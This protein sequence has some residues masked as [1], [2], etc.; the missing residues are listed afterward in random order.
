MHGSAWCS[1]QNKVFLGFALHEISSRTSL[2]LWKR[3]RLSE[4]KGKKERVTPEFGALQLCLIV[5][6]R[7]ILPKKSKM[8]A[9]N[10]SSL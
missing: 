10:L 4:E 9:L 8:F 1:K 6:I 3:S 5:M 2:Q 7:N